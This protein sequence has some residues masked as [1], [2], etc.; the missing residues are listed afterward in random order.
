MNTRDDHTDTLLEEED[1]R[2]ENFHRDLDQRD[3]QLE[4][5]DATPPPARCWHC[6]GSGVRC[7]EFGRD[8][9]ADERQ[10]AATLHGHRS[11]TVEAAPIDPPVDQA[12]DEICPGCH[13]AGEIEPRRTLTPLSGLG[14][15]NPRHDRP[16]TCP[17]C[18]G[19]GHRSAA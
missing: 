14:W 11:G 2:T 16:R 18:G 1:Q 7:C 5:A 6:G 17:D 12:A 3:R 8:L 19:E 13:G 15:R 4:R 10:A 9:R